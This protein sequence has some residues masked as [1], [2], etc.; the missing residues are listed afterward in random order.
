MTIDD[1]IKGFVKSP[2][3]TRYAFAEQAAKNDLSPA[4]LHGLIKR[5]CGRQ[6]S[7]HGGKYRPRDKAAAIEDVAREAVKW[8]NRCEA[9]IE[10]KSTEK[11]TNMLEPLLLEFSKWTAEAAKLC[12]APKDAESVAER[13]RTSLKKIQDM[14]SS[15]VES[16]TDRTVKRQ[17]KAI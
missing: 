15:C 14:L 6:K 3:D 13:M 16:L 1:K 12:K 8:I 17:K 10:F 5:E 7:S 11:P 9:A 2:A 4:Q